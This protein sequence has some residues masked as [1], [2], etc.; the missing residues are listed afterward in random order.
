MKRAGVPVIP[1]SEGVLESAAAA[2]E[3]ADTIGYPVILKARDGGGA[4][5]RMVR[6]PGT[7]RASTIWRK[8]AQAAFASGAL[9]LEV[10][11]ARRLRELRSQPM[12]TGT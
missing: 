8:Q 10:P 12:R 6:V 11:R 2:L 4:G 1:G 5:M 7:S 9:Y 3:L